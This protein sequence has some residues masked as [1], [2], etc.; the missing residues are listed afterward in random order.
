MCKREIGESIYPSLSSGP[1]SEEKIARFTFRFS[2]EVADFNF[3][4]TSSIDLEYKTFYRRLL[5][6]IREAIQRPM[7][8]ADGVESTDSSLRY[9]SMT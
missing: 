5:D 9:G 6:S 2:V 8:N 4:E 1:Y 7:M 3:G